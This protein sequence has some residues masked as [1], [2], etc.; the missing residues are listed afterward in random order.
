[1][2]SLEGKTKSVISSHLPQ[3]HTAPDHRHFAYPDSSGSCDLHETLITTQVALPP[4]Q[5]ARLTMPDIDPAALSRPAISTTPILP[6]KTI[7][8]PAPSVPKPS[9]LSHV[10]PRIDLEPL[11]TAL[12][13]AIGEHWGTYKESISLFVMGA[14]SPIMYLRACS[15]LLKCAFSY[16]LTI[17]LHFRPVEPAGTLSKDRLLHCDPSR[18]DRT[19]P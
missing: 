2:T 4:P 11:Y 3:S 18:R 7:S 16:L 10:P 14:Y 9:K 12:K 13:Q 1:V 19:P 6:P 8:A 5:Q 15:N 17:F